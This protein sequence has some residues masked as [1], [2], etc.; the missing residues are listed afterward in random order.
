MPPELGI[1]VAGGQDRVGQGDPLESVLFWNSA[2]SDQ[3]WVALAS[4]PTAR[5]EA[6]KIYLS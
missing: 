5:Y 6:L 1:L 2:A 4:L 3:A